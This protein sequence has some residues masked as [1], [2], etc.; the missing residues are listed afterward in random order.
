MR[1]RMTSVYDPQ[2]PLRRL[3]LV[4]LQHAAERIMAHDILTAKARLGFRRRERCHDWDVAKTLV[5]ATLV[6]EWGGYTFADRSVAYL[7]DRIEASNSA[8]VR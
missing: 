6:I 5:W 4:V 7:A 8:G 2:P 1:G 3:A